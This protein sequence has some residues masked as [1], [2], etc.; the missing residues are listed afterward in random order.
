MT[1]TVIDWDLSGVNK[2]ACERFTEGINHP[3][4]KK[5]YKTKIDQ[6]LAY[7]EKDADFIADLGREA[8]GDSAKSQGL[9]NLLNEVLSEIM[10]EK[11]HK[12]NT[13]RYYQRVLRKFFETNGISFKYTF[14]A[15]IEIRQKSPEL[16]KRKSAQPMSKEE[17]RAIVTRLGNS[18][19]T[20]MCFLSRDTG[21]RLQDCMEL[22]VKHIQPILNEKHPEYFVFDD[23]YYPLKNVHQSQ[24]KQTEPLPA[25]LIMGYE[26]IG[27]VRIWMR[28]R[29]W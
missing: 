13:M 18:R 20:A 26:S 6:F 14:R 27:Y 12:I 19:N 17:M 2:T 22:K 23:L 7:V 25:T 29:V 9:Q 3:S 4:A 15:N 28:E 10:V 21:L 11:K 5:L 1:T 8:V 24:A 16:F